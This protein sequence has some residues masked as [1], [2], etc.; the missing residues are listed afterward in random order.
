MTESETVVDGLPESWDE[1]SAL[2]DA[3]WRTYSTLADGKSITLAG[4]GGS[5][6]DSVTDRLPPCPEEEVEQYLTRR[7]ERT[8]RFP[9]SPLDHAHLS[10]QPVQGKRV[11]P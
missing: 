8:R 3:L 5:W 4:D 2:H 6:P 11:A 1:G 7:I 10:L 9:I